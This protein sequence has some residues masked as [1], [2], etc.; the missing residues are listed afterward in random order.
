MRF[1]NLV[2]LLQIL[3]INYQTMN[4]KL[5]SIVF[6]FC[7]IVSN[8]QTSTSKISV[9]AWDG[10][11]VAGY[12]DDGGFLNFGGPSIKWNKK[13]YSIGLGMLPSLRFKD[14]KDAI[15]NGLPKN[16]FITPTLGAGIYFVKKHFI[17]QIPT[18][19]TPKTAKTDGKW[20][21]GL[22]V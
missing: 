6:W 15:A 4:V 11:V 18:Y 5:L 2:N 17:V 3:S 13:P 14:D 10:S 8:A 22:G 9:S 21:F 12:V 19:Y 20:N 16:Q 1:K 7:C